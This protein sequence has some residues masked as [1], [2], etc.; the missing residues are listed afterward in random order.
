MG[1]VLKF[2]KKSFQASP[3]QLRNRDARDKVR[4]LVKKISGSMENLKHEKKI[5]GKFEIF[6]I[7]V[8]FEKRRISFWKHSW[9]KNHLKKSL[10]FIFY[11][12]FKKK[13]RNSSEILRKPSDSVMII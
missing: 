12:F 9:G 13:K 7:T 2:N 10:F 5:F 11:N 1:F 8:F 4:I 6:E 3:K